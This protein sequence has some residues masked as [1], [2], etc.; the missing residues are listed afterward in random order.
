MQL[1]DL[2][3]SI[4]WRNFFRLTQI[5]RPSKHEE[6]VIEYLV[7]FAKT[8]NLDFLKDK[9][10]N[11]IIRKPATKGYENR[12]GV[13]LQ[14]HVDMVPQKNTGTI[15]DFV[16]DPISTV[17]EGDWVMAKGTTLGADNGIG[18]AAALA[19]LEDSTAEH[20]PLELLLTIDEETGMTGTFNLE[21]DYINGSIL[22][23]LDSEDEGELCVGCAGGLDTSL[24]SIF[25][26]EPVLSCYSGFKISLTG[27]KGGHSGVDIH[28]GRGNANKLMNRFLYRASRDLD[29]RLA[30]F[31][32]GS[33]RNAIPREA[34]ALVVIPETQKRN[35]KLLCSEFLSE[36]K[37]ELSSVE[38]NIVFLAETTEPPLYVMSK[39]SQQKFLDLMYALPNGV[40]RMSPEFDGVVETSVNIAI[41]KVEN[42]RVQIHCLLRSSIE[43]AKIDLG[44]TFLAIA[45]LAGYAIIHSGGYPGWRPN[46]S[47]R[48]LEIMKEVYV[49]K[50]KKEPVVRVI[51]AGL[52]C[53]IIGDIYRRMDMI[54]FGPT[55][56]Y[57]HSPDEKVQ[58]ST[59]KNFYEFL[60]DTL[61]RV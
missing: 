61:K 1:S 27:L 43:S 40:V 3:P 17:I 55:I 6:R 31:E 30:N 2:A 33:L 8:R 16:N 45:S 34:F 13:V 22:L 15:H 21:S 4:V 41:V 56:K 7:Q 35:F 42:K 52:E 18:V 46:P 9:V 28:L 11:V 49:A 36:I 58:I 10:G 44:D 20:G 24:E 53:G 47:S 25:E 38:P 51:H 23:N 19:V 14:A 32:G 5:P 29:L 57:P 54:S 50:F 48:I 59:V 37:N 39:L 12:P 60:L 26:T